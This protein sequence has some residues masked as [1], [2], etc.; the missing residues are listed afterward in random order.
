LQKQEFAHKQKRRENNSVSRRIFHFVFPR[1]I[2][3]WLLTH[4][5][6]LPSLKVLCS[7]FAL[8]ALLELTLYYTSSTYSL[9]RETK[10][11]SHQIPKI[12]T[13]LVL[14]DGFG[15]I[16]NQMLQLSKAMFIANMSQVP[17][18][19]HDG[20]Y[21]NL[22]MKY[23]DVKYLEESPFDVRFDTTNGTLMDSRELQYMH[24]PSFGM[25]HDFNKYLRLIDVVKWIRP[26]QHLMESA[27]EYMNRALPK[28]FVGF[29]H[30]AEVKRWCFD[31]TEP[32]LPDYCDGNV[33]MNFLRKMIQRRHPEFE[34]HPVYISTD[35]KQARI[36]ENL[37]KED[38]ENTFIHDGYEGHLAETLID[39]WCS[40]FVA[41][42]SHFD[43]SWIYF[44]LHCYALECT[45][46]Y[47]ST[48][49][50]CENLPWYI[51][52]GSPTNRRANKEDVGYNLL[53]RICITYFLHLYKTYEGL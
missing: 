3:T 41:C 45:K 20:K 34:N 32:D 38:P 26:N 53:L 18:I 52:E 21:K 36:F 31:A 22:V 51:L 15:G 2:T 16:S 42:K 13:P 37:L 1:N 4:P 11:V 8:C 14:V 43:E 29:H 35:Y 19:I 23:L 40:D 12:L 6:K 28:E 50:E 10:T 39:T 44:K 27:S 24:H 9:L 46:V 5:W 25:W 47:T 33:T 49:I 30:R 7:A 48:E 17:L